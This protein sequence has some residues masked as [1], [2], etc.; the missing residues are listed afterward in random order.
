MESAGTPG[1]IEL[2]RQFKTLTDASL[3]RLDVSDLLDTLLERVRSVLRVDTAVVLLLDLHAGQ[4]VA[5]A[6]KGL[7]EE[8]R[9]GFRIAVGAGFAG[10]I[11]Q[12]GQPLVLDEVT[13]AN[14]VNPLLLRTGIRSLLGVPILATGN[15]VGVLHVGTVTPRTFTADDVML[16]QVAADRAGVAGQS[17]LQQREH[18]AALALQRSLVP[19]QSPTVAGLQV[20]VRYVPGHE[21]GVGGDWY[22]MF[23]LPSGW[24]GLVI[25]DVSG[26][27]LASAVVMGRIR[28]A[29]RAYA[30]LSDNPAQALMS[31]DRKV[32]H[33]E[34]GALTTALYAMISP[35]RSTVQLSTAGHLRPV[36]AVPGQ[37]PALVDMPVDAPLG[38]SR[39]AHNRHTTSINLPV[40]ALMLCYTDGLV[41]RRHR[42]IDVGIKTL[43]NTVR[44]DDPETVCATVMSEIAQDRPT[45]DI[46]I[47][48]IRH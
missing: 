36:L 18:T 9:Q 1:E 32:Q 40:G 16:L 10:R 19:P 27:G 29:L 30:L 12:T 26:H 34:A 25:G 24:L 35:D 14:V 44:P 41:E 45:D 38:V 28:S 5:T 17:R 8:V 39:W 31:L 11:A 6:S 15:L 2:L 4:L 42:I 43:L 3:S 37:Q 48:A 7:E 21:F 20:A 33:F 22:D 46:A 23:S 47:L 13:S